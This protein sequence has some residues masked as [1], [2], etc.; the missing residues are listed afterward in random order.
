MNEVLKTGL[1]GI[2]FEDNIIITKSDEYM[3]LH[4]D[5]ELPQF[6]WGKIIGEVNRD[7]FALTKD[8]RL[9]VSEKAFKVINKFCIENALIEDFQ[10]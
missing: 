4:F 10:D 1:S 7:D 3:S 5:K 2:V 8:Y 9:L 6:Y